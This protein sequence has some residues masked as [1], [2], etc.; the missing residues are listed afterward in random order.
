MNS[1]KLRKVCG[2]N[3]IPK[4]RL[5]HFPNRLVV[6]LTHLFNHCFHISSSCCKEAKVTTL[7]KPC[8]DPHFSQNMR[9][10]SLLLTTGKLFEK[11]NLKIAQRHV[12]VPAKCKLIWVL[13]WS[14]HDTS[15]HDAYRPCNLKFQ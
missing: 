11:S 6:H 12:G 3:C 15:M 7:P 13:R 5:K 10:I 14:Q 4:E 8:K 9:P 2:I 1:L